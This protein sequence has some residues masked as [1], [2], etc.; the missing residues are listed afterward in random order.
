M[1][2]SRPSGEHRRY[3]RF[4]AHGAIFTLLSPHQVVSVLCQF[5]AAIWLAV[6]SGSFAS[7]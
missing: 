2:E 4:S 5:L 6:R 1:R 7:F 3:G